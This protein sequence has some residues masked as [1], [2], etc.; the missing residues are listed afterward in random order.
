MVLVSRLE[1]GCAGLSG[2][3]NAPLSR[4]VAASVPPGDY[5]F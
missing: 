3:L 5:I 2:K 1:I 4:E